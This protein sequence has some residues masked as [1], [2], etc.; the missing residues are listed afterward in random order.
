MDR[1]PDGQQVTATAPPLVHLEGYP[2]LYEPTLNTTEAATF[3]ATSRSQLLQL[4]GQGILPVEP[5]KLGRRHRWPTC[6]IAD[7]LG[8]PW[9]LVP[10]DQAQAA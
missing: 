8:I 1:C 4:T 2:D 6:K 10:R 9:T 3:L 5:L 7:A